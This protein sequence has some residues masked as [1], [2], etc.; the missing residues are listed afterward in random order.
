MKRNLTIQLDETVIDSARVIAAR[1]AM[2]ISRLV[3]MEIEL[4]VEKD[5]SYQRAQ[6][7]ARAHL[8][9]GFHLGGVTLPKRE[10]L[11]DR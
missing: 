7:Q 10:E 4:L 1:R 6:A 11:Y 9:K 8:E 3:A 2:S 5:D